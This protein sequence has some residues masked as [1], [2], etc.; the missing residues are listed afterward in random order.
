MT[1]TKRHTN[2]ISRLTT[3]LPLIGYE[4]VRLELSVSPTGLWEKVIRHSWDIEVISDGRIYATKGN[5]PL[6]VFDD[7]S[8]ARVTRFILDRIGLH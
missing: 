8:N 7:F 4:I 5:M 1:I 3:I 2:I 6:S